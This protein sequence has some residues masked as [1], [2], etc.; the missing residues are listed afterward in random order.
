MCLEPPDHVEAACKMLDTGQTAPVALTPISKCF[1][2][3]VAGHLSFH[4]TDSAVGA[5][6]LLGCTG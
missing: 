2:S 1:F 3:K 6:I 4:Y 5:L